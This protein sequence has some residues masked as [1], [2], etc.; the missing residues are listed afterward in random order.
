MSLAT[1]QS[2]AHLLYDILISAKNIVKPLI[3]AI[4][5]TPVRSIT[6]VLVP[7][8]TTAG[9]GL[10]TMATLVSAV[11]SVLEVIHSFTGTSSLSL[12]LVNGSNYGVPWYFALITLTFQSFLLLGHVL[13]KLIRKT[14]LLLNLILEDSAVISDVFLLLEQCVYKGAE[15]ETCKKILDPIR[16]AVFET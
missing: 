10:T 2:L 11:G 16:K 6:A 3:Q 15:G 8:T 4:D 13:F 5:F 1:F 9:Q 12:E 7:I 14:Y